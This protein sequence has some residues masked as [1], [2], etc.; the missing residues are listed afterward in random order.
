MNARSPA[1]TTQR[2]I[3]DVCFESA[4]SPR[5]MA[6]STHGRSK[7][8]R[9]KRFTGVVQMFLRLPPPTDINTEFNT[10][11]VSLSTFHWM[12]KIQHQDA[13]AASAPVAVHFMKY[14]KNRLTYF[15]AFSSES[16]RGHVVG[17]SSVTQIPPGRT[18]MEELDCAYPIH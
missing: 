14:Q 7:E 15:V 18:C 17:K 11:R 6:L 12:E 4:T 1:L 10:C 16:R 13:K 8:S 2:R 5:S 9:T 3:D